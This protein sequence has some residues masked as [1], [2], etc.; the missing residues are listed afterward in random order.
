[1]AA[2]NRVV[3]VAM[4]EGPEAALQAIETIAD[5]PSLAKYYLA[6]RS[7]RKPKAVIQVVAIRPRTQPIESPLLSTSSRPTTVLV[8]QSLDVRSGVPD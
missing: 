6:K 8:E 7:T 3:A 2:L 4:V 1:M 5:D